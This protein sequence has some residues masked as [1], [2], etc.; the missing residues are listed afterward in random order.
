MLHFQK[1]SEISLYTLKTGDYFTYKTEI[2]GKRFYKKGLKVGPGYMVPVG[3]LCDT[4]ETAQK[5]Y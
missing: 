3:L 2:N 4:I 5:T 1:L